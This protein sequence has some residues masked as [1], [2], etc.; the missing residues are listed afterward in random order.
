MQSR[1]DNPKRTTMRHIFSEN[2]V[3]Y[4]HKMGLSQREMAESLGITKERVASWEN[5]LCYPNIEAMLK[6]CDFIGNKNI[7]KLL[8]EPVL[9]VAQMGHAVLMDH[10]GQIIVPT[11]AEYFGMDRFRILGKSRK[12]KVVYA[13]HICCFL[14]TCRC[15]LSLNRTAQ[16][17][18]PG[19]T[20]HTS[21]IHG[22]NAIK[23]RYKVNDGNVRE[24]VENI[25]RIANSELSYV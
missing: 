10:L 5:N 13:R 20:D 19:I 6:I 23:D 24:D 18:S 9:D 22:R 7:Y 4:R 14:L 1:V 15:E 2:L 25:W 11:A 21:V 8:T 12:E 17:L 3:K 16:L